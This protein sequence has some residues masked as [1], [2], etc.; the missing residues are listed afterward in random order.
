MTIE[1]DVW[2]VLDEYLPSARPSGVPSSRWSRLTSPPFF[3]PRTKWKAPS[4]FARGTIST[5]IWSRMPARVGSASSAAS[6][7]AASPP[8]GSFP[9]CWPMINTVGLPALARSPPSPGEGRA[10]TSSG[11]ARASCEV[12]M[13]RTRRSG[14]RRE[15]S[16]MNAC[17]SFWLVKSDLPG[18]NAGVA[19]STS[20]SG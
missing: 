10:K 1:H 15:S 5:L 9:C 17:S 3:K 16:S 14:E 12:P 7:R 13:M 19:I 8:A 4:G 2:P 6:A 20:G 11:I 18:L